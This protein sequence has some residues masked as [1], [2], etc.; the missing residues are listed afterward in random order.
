MKRKSMEKSLQFI[1]SPLDF[2]SLEA[3]ARQR[4]QSWLQGL[5]E[6][7]V[8]AFLGRDKYERGGDNGTGLGEAKVEGQN[9]KR[10]GYR[11]GY[12]KPRMLTTRM[13]TLELRRPRV[14]GLAEGEGFE[15]KIL[16]LFASKTEEVD[17]TLLGLYLHGLSLGDFEL[18]MRG[19]LGE[20][21][22]LSSSSLFRLKEAWQQEYQ[23]WKAQSLQSLEVVYLWVDG[24]YVKA[25][26]D[27][28]QSCLLVALAGLTDGSKTFLAIESGYRESKESWASLLRDL[29]RRGLAT[30]S[31]VIGDGALGIWSA[32]SE[33]FPFAGQQRCWNHR[34][35]NILGQIPK[36]AQPQA[37]LLLKNITSA[38]SAKQALKA[39]TAFQDWATSKGYHKAAG[40]IAHD[41]ERMTAYFSFPKEHWKHLKTTNPI[42]SPFASARLRTDA[43]KRFKRADNAEAML[44]KLLQVA[45]TTFRRLQ[46]AHLLPEV[47]AGVRYYDGIRLE[48]PPEITAKPSPEEVAA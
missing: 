33:V 36:R 4:I 16:P 19:L 24:I 12:G 11:N 22:A 45:E 28:E 42:E 27:K 17:E 21:A 9:L 15:S 20:G 10:K 34:K 13:G 37:S 26:L 2:K 46:H 18:A 43:A 38:D 41:W 44:W 30:P 25:G 40:L 48:Y 35:T 47:F 1:E 5:L 29:H 39:R 32:L 6:E 3:Y 8:T 7:E 31:L 14:R 23:S